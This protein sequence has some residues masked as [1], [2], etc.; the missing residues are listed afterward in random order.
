[1]SVGKLIRYGLPFSNVVATGTATNTITPGRTLENFQL[2]L[3]GTTLTKAMLSLV[4]IKANGKVIMEGT[5]TEID[6]LNAYRGQTTAAAYLDLHFADYSMLS[7]VDRMAGAFD[8]SLGVANITSEITVAGATAPILT[9]ILV[10]SAQ[11]KTTNGAIA[12]FAPLL[13][14]FLRYPFSVATGG[15]LPVTVPFGPQSGAII[16]RAHV[17]SAAGLMTG[18]TV[19]QDGLV[20]H[21][22]LAAENTYMQLK[23]GRV[24][25]TNMYTIDFCLDGNLAK[26]LD[27][28]DAK[29]LEWLFA[30]S[31]A[32][33]GNVIIEYLDPLGNL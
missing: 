9:P 20:I 18:A 15:T 16:K 12:P 26:A 13:T 5:G 31:G 11:Q 6:K 21:E 7:E 25:Q 29:S 27:T 33:S 8:T 30:F 17:L 28:R 14:K 19:K 3:G 23:H 32:E 22:S 1:M 10:E 4:K 2:K 24:A